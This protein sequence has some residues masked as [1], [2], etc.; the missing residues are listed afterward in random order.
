MGAV[1]GAKQRRDGGAGREEIAPEMVERARGDA[2]AFGQIY[3]QYLP[4][5]YAFCRRYTHT[6]EE[7]EDLTAETFARA[8]AGISDYRDR[9]LPFSSW[10]LRIAANTAADQGRRA[11]RF[12]MFPLSA[13]REPWEH[14]I[15]QWEHALWLR[16]HVEALPADQQEVIRL[17]FYEDKPFAEIATSMNR[18]EGAVKQLLR[19]ALGA[20]DIGIR[21]ES[22]G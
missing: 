17:R 21:R 15:E 20:L 19:R 4:R 5:V 8:F 12:G 14:R 18:S 22:R 1:E 11:R 9:G 6:R 7:A 3:S 16:S 13:A 10:L 2:A